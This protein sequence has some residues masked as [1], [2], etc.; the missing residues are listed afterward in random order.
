MTVLVAVHAAVATVALLL[1]GQ[2]LLRRRKGDALHRRVGAVWLAAMYFTVVSSFWIQELEPGSFSWIRGLS[3]FTFCTLSAALWAALTGRALLHRA[4]AT[5][6]YFGLV[7]AFL[8]A[9]AVPQRDIPQLLVD[10]PATFTAALLG[11]CAVAV[12]VVRLAGRR[13][14]RRLVAAVR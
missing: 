12:V 5:G 3:A 6:S 4:F 9:V 8:G 13:S 1:G 7:G 11:C 2:L 10:S 14:R